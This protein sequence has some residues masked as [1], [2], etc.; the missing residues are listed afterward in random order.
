MPAPRFIGTY[1]QTTREIDIE[2]LADGTYAVTLDG[3]RREVDARH[4]EGGT[5]SLLV[6]GESYDI[7]LEVAGQTEREGRYN[8]LIRSSVF[9]LS[10]VDERQVRLGAG[11]GVMREEGPQ[12]MVAPMPGKIVKLLV[13]P[14][15]Q[16][17][18]GQAVIVIEAMK[19]ENELRAPTAGVVAR[20]FVAEGDA[21][22]ARVKL[23]A[24]E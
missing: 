10:V 18:D 12:V 6:D 20:I 13:S 17:D 8:T 16:V 14:G 19:M 5:W 22:E 4:F 21:V 11:S 7:E 3:V 23:L 24:L 1:G 15:D 2:P 9:E